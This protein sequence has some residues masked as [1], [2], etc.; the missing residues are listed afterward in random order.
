MKPIKFLIL[1]AAVL[2]FSCGGDDE[3]KPEPS[4]D[5]T[6]KSQ[7]GN[8][9]KISGANASWQSYPNVS[10]YV[11]AA[12]DQKFLTIDTPPLKDIKKESNGTWSGKTFRFEYLEDGDDIEVKHGEFVPVVMKL[13]AD[14]KTLSWTGTHPDT[15][16]IVGGTSF[17]NSWTKVE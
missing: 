2:L 13:S 16:T 11:Q 6:W 10:V 9:A 1:A 3:V 14:G 8:I 5:G 4:I 15:F 17:D 12:I 7:L